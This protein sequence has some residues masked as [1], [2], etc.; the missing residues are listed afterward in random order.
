MSI[1]RRGN[2]WWYE[3]RIRGQR[4]RESSYSR[5]ANVAREAARKRR[6]HIVD[7]ISYIAA[8]RPTLFSIHA[9]EWQSEMQPHWRPNT[10]RVV[11]HNLKRLGATFG[12]M[13]LTDIAATDIRKYQ[14]RR[15]AAGMSGATINLEVGT[16]RAV[17]RR[18]R[19]WANLQPDVRMMR[20]R[21]DIGRALGG[22]ESS[23]LLK[24]CQKSRSRSLYVAVLMSIHTGLRNFELRA[25]KWGNIDWRRKV[26]RVE[27][28]KTAGGEG[29]EVPLTELAL[30]VL[31]AWRDEFVHA[32]NHF[33]F[34]AQRVGFP[35][36]KGLAAS[37]DPTKP[38]GS[39][40]RAWTRA[41]KEAEVECRW[42]DLRHTFASR[43]A[44][45]QVSDATIM[46]MMGH[47]S[48][49]MKE[50]YSHTRL[51]AKRRAVEGLR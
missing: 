44:E 27:I 20:A 48:V 2:T 29:R 22:D 4:V 10:R 5:S 13:L 47:M 42:H 51:E 38:M 19:L 8:R 32:P 40:D 23:R 14:A 35:S 45:G 24:A 30:T 50:R 21:T 46:S 9:K 41:R 1:F 31:R 16:L 39:W 28:S 33:I 18:H 3:F 26:L 11:K 15:D 25:L 7:G 12:K 36:K 43:L 34:P 49:K 37:V 6:R 17:L